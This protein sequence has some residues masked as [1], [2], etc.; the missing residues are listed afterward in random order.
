MG[1]DTSAWVS[2]PRT[3]TKEQGSPLVFAVAG[4]FDVAKGQNE[5]VEAFTSPAL[6]DR[7]DWRIRFFGGGDPLV[8]GPLL[9][10]SS[11]GGEPLVDLHGSYLPEELPLLFGSVDVGLSV[12][13]FETFHRVTREYLLSGVPVITSETF[14]ALDVIREGVNGLVFDS[15]DSADLARKCARLL[16]D[17]GLLRRLSEGAEAT[18]VRSVKEEADELEALYEELLAERLNEER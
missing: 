6:A 4:V 11:A 7:D 15:T 18:K 16:D 5:I 17:R 12:S 8:V 10:A 1:L 9:R 13:R 3:R 2:Q 14:G